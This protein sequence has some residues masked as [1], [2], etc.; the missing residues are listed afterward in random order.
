M[1]GSLTAASSANT[2]TPAVDG[3]IS[4]M[5]KKTGDAV[6]VFLIQGNIKASCFSNTALVGES[7]FAASACIPVRAGISV[8]I[9]LKG[10]GST[11]DSA[12]FIPCQGNV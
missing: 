12:Y 2:Y 3:W 10:S 7:A 4:V 9:H 6:A 1:L 11:I 8:D 5:L